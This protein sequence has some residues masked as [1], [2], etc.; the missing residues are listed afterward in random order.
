MVLQQPRYGT[1]VQTPG[2]MAEQAVQSEAVL[3]NW[4]RSQSLWASHSSSTTST[5]AA[6]AGRSS[7]CSR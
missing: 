7:G 4:P 3:Q 1:A 5:A 2:L 6:A